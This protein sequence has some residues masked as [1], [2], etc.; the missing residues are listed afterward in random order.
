MKKNVICKL[1]A[2]GSIA[3]AVGFFSAG[4]GQPGSTTVPQAQASD[5]VQA[6]SA[7]LD[8]DATDALGDVW[9]EDYARADGY[10][11]PDASAETVVANAWLDQE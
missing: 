3:A 6:G 5:I 2:I 10:L 8:S 9:S 7:G 11:W 1:L 4:H